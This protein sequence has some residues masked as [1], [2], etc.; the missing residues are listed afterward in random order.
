[1]MAVIGVL[2]VLGMGPVMHFQKVQK[3]EIGL[4]VLMVPVMLHQLDQPGRLIEAE[5][6]NQ[7][8]SQ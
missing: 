6:R 7:T 5:T 8:V 2:L 1:M 4:L 3:A